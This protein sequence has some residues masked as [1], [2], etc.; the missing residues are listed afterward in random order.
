MSWISILSVA[1]IGSG[2]NQLLLIIIKEDLSVQGYH[3]FL[4]E[5][6]LVESALMC[7]AFLKTMEK[8]LKCLYSVLSLTLGFLGL[9]WSH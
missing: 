5:I 2:N 9:S 4:T 3:L 1:Y 8:S 7:R 6:P